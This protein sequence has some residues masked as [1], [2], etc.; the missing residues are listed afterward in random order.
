MVFYYERNP[1]KYK[2][3][4]IENYKKNNQDISKQVKND[5]QLYSIYA[6]MNTTTNTEECNTVNDNLYEVKDVIDYDEVTGEP[7]NTEAI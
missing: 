3:L 5:W 2:E 7:F 1:E 6:N 4:F